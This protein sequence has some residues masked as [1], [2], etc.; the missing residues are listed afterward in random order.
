MKKQ[1]KKCLYEDNHPLNLFIDDEG[2]CS[3][4]RVHEEKYKIDW[5][6]KEIMLKDL[7]KEYK[8]LN[9]NYDCIVPVTGTAD[10][11]FIVDYV[12]NKL[13][14]NPLLVSY[15]S[16]SINKLG[17]QNLAY[18]KTI[19][20]L[21]HITKTIS[22]RDVKAIT[23]LTMNKLSSIYWHIH[24]GKTVFPVQVAKNLEIP[25]IIW[26]ENEATEQVGMYSYDSNIEMSRK[27]RREHILLGVEAEDLIEMNEISEESLEALLYPEVSEIN[28]YGIRGIYLSNYLEWDN[29]EQNKFVHKK[30]KFN[31]FNHSRTY[32][33][34]QNIDCYL[35]MT[36]HDVIK[37]NKCG[38]SKVLDHL[39]R[40]I[41]HKRIKKIDALE[42]NKNISNKD[43]S[44][45]IL[46]NFCSWL[47]LEKTSF[48]GFFENYAYTQFYKNKNLKVNYPNFV[49]S[50]ESG[51][52]A[53]NKPFLIGDFFYDVF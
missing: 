48:L 20:N 49:N 27:Y 18:L 31:I 8:N 33:P 21:D 17:W 5:K 42:I 14:L 19:F 16:H 24:A 45:E 50:E 52:E 38:Y 13:N 6:D 44:E 12:V 40:D 43:F 1:C 2:V 11:F 9:N 28:K 10:S 7:V 26:G 22:P 37:Y 23:R 25:L 36:L 39:T 34:Y 15:N 53:F 4:C 29:Y 35:Y 41:R 46:E 3:G 32:D 47:D 30:Y 51:S